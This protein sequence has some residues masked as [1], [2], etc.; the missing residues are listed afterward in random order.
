M[1][2]YLNC[3]V[4]FEAYREIARTRFFV[5]KSLLLE[6]ILSTMEMDG[7]KYL[8]ITRPRRFGKSVMANMVA[9]FFGKA[10]D[11]GTLFKGLAI[12]GNENYK[13]HL[14]K[15]N[16][17]YI[18]FSEVPRDCINYRQYIARIQ[19]GI[20]HDLAKE[21]DDLS[22]DTAKATW[23][24]MTDI[25][26]EKGEKFVFV[27]DEWDAVFHMSFIAREDK[28]DY[29]LFLKSLLKGKIYVELAYM[30]GVLPIAKYSSGSELN[31]FVEYDMTVM[32]RFSD[33]F[34]FME[35]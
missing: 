28:E 3:S 14:N 25:F 24:I 18:D 27:M 23:D 7:Q 1:G 15:H 32:E 26:E 4:P 29:L 21:Y 2:K 16:V 10:V 33:C 35:E 8:C 6:D 11:A 22:I 9:A 34:G 20:N 17:I 5:D 30:T 31:M 19:D 13:V 12:A